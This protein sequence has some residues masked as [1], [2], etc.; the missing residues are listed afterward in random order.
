MLARGFDGEVRLLRPLR[1]NMG[2][3]VFLF[4]WTALFVVMR[5]VDVS[6]LLGELAGGALP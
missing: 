6:R 3:W 2:E 1:F 5:V 4:G